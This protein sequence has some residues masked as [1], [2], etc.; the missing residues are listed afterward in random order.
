MNI[1]QIVQPLDNRDAVERGKVLMQIER[2]IRAG[3]YDAGTVLAWIAEVMPPET[4]SA[5]NRP[6][7][8]SRPA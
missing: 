5:M 7:S 3:K 8:L 2:M 1:E 4:G 6:N